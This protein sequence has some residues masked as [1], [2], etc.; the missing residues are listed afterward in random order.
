MVVALSFHCKCPYPTDGRRPSTMACMKSRAT[1]SLYAQEAEYLPATQAV[2]DLG[3][4]LKLARKRAQE[5]Q[6]SAGRKIGDVTHSSV[7]QWERA[8]SLIDTLNLV[9]AA[10]VY[11]ESLDYL[12]FG[13]RGTI[14]DRINALPE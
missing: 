13:M 10:Q 5:T 12:V 6:P 3:R 1:T 4:R 9:L 2:I 7:G 14:E 8:E 11:R